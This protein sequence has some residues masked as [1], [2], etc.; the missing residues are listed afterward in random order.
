MSEQ[1]TR[2]LPSGDPGRAGVGGSRGPDSPQGPLRKIGR[3]TI[4]R[5]IASGGMG[6]VYEAVQDKPRRSVAIKTMSHSVT[7]PSALR[8]F[9]YEAQLLARLRHPCIAQIYEAGTHD[10]GGTTV[11]FFAMEYI[12]NARPITEY[13]ET[14]KLTSRDR[15]ELFAK[16]CDAIHHGHQKGIIHRDLKPMNILVDSSGQPRIIDFGVARAIDSD[17]AGATQQTNVGQLVG[18]VQYMSPEQC[19]ADPSDIDTRS[20]I[21]ALGMVLYEMLCGSLPYDVSTVSICEAARLIREADPE[22]LRLQDPSLRGEVD[23]IVFKALAKDRDRRYQSAYGL[24]QDIR[25]YL[26]GE[27]IAARPPSFAYQVRVFARRNKTLIGAVAAVFVVLVAGIV[28]SS[29]MYGS[30]QRERLRA[31]AESVKALRTLDFLQHML[32]TADPNKEG[33]E[34]RL[35][36]LLNRYSA[37]LPVLED[38]PEVEAAV[39]TTLGLGYQEMGLLDEAEPHLTRALALREELLGAEFPD[40]LSSMY[41]LA[42]LYHDQRQLDKVEPLTLR[43]Y[44]L[45]QQV[46]GEAHPDTL[47]SMSELA[48]LRQDQGR[49]AEA[50]QLKRQVVKMRRDL[51]GADDPGTQDAVADLAHTLVVQGNLDEAGRLFENRSPPAGLGIENWYQGEG[52]IDLAGDPATVVL[53]WEV[54]CPYCQHQVPRLQEMYPRF[55]QRGLQMIGLIEQRLDT[56]PE[57]VRNFIATRNLTYPVA[58]TATDTQGYFGLSGVPTA[59]LIRNGR[60]VWCGSASRVSEDLLDGLLDGG[61]AVTPAERAALDGGF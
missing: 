32:W 58:R 20:D 55:H 1:E 5:V 24:A 41:H 15:L 18:T 8:R 19:D 13:A 28:V 40:T 49:Y 56:Q 36:D 3:Y 52:T 2:D 16:V 30:A 59:A 39:R 14:K 25:R 7:S 9:E 45:R 34:V 33:P 10:E 42:G 46:L 35:V 11:P 21:Y 23:T 26:A 44:E 54:W 51:F 43:A 60:V 4:K 12:P 57:E 27:A 53:F 38:E 6:T 47:D 29:S 61:N 22:K 48:W 37:I 17:M 50:E 31:Q